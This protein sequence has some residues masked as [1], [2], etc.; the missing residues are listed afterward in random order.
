MSDTIELGAALRDGVGKGSARASRR[1]GHVP[2]L[3]YG[4]KKPPLS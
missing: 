2:A 4:Y 3:I 1:G